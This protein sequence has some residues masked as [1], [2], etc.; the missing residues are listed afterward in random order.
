MIPGNTETLRQFHD[1]LNQPN[2]TKRRIMNYS[3][4]DTLLNRSDFRQII[5]GYFDLRQISRG[6]TIKL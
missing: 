1:A 2:H 6:D 4:V 5:F 3:I